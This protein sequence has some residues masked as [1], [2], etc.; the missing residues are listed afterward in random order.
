MDPELKSEF[1]RL[2]NKFFPGESLP[3]TFEIASDPCDVQNAKPSEKWRC[4][5]CDLAKVKAGTSLAFDA[6]SIT[7]RGGLR[8]CGYQHERPPEFEYFL[9]YGIEGT[10]EG[11]RYK[12]TPE[13]VNE[14]QQDIAIIPAS[15]KVIIFKRWDHLEPEDNPSV[16][17][18]FARGEVLSGLFTLANFDR[19]DPFGVITPMGAGCS[20]IVHYPWIEEQSSDPRA[21]LGMM[22]PSARP[23][24]PLDTLTFAI[25]MK[26]FTTMIRDMEE[27]FLITPSWDKVRKKMEQSNR[28]HTHQ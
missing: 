3:I 28:I 6:R 15:G 17:I 25:P 5:I 13:I 7:C 4:I 10:L 2:W 16:V 23:C 9:S 18:F 8:Y 12:K 14:W 11:E 1:I 27:S 22:D 21:V 20:S 19:V 26:K 24:V